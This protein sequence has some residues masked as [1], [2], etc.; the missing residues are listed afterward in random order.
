MKPAAPA[1]TASPIPGWTDTTVQPAGSAPLR[2]RIYGRRPAS[3]NLPLVLHFHAGAFTSGSLEGGAPIA[4]L[5]AEAG[6][7]VVSVDYP[8]A[9][10]HPFPQAIEAGYAALTWAHKQRAKLTGPDAPLVIAGEEAG[11][12]IAA[13]VSLMARDRQR[14]QLAG[15]ILF[16]P[17]LDACV[18]TASSRKAKVGHAEC[19]WAL[20]WHDYLCDVADPSHPYAVPGRAMRLAGLPSTLLITAE[21]D[22]IRDEALAFARRL[23]AASVPTQEL[24]VPGATGWP[25]SYGAA[26]PPSAQWP[27]AALERCRQFLSSVQTMNLPA[28]VPSRH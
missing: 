9:P 6:A 22:P 23:G 14:P 10:A 17:M 25:A 18:A 24:I 27:A 3:G 8:L 5:L 20:G 4:A 15:Q 11:G 28:P 21:D 12:N 7:I 19:K 13:A 2:A 1:Q 16:S 26:P